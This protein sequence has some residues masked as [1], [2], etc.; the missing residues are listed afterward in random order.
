MSL[1]GDGSGL[2]MWLKTFPFASFK[3]KK[4]YNI[5]IFQVVF[6]TVVSSINCFNMNPTTVTAPLTNVSVSHPTHKCAP[7]QVQTNSLHIIC[8]NKGNIKTWI[9][10]VNL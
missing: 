6:I 1:H 4:T 9:I 5:M 2:N 8:Y 7:L 3:V 10:E